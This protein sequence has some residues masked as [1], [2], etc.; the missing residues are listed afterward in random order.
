MFASF[1]CM[2]GNIVYALALPCDSLMMVLVGRLLTGFGSA[3]VI[4]RRYIG[5]KKL[6]MLI[7]GHSKMTNQNVFNSSH[8]NN[9]ISADYYSIEDRTSGMADFVSA[10]ALGMAVGPG[11][12]ALLSAVAPDGQRNSDAWWTIETAPGCKF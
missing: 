7:L 3:R 6:S 4:N 9:I 2:A 12:A 5:K 1:C 11:I 8:F 10:S